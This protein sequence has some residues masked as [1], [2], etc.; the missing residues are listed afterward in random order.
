MVKR[1]TIV[2][3]LAWLAAVLPAGSAEA[4]FPGT[5]GLIAGL[6]GNPSFGI[7]TVKPDGTNR[8]L[9]ATPPSG[10]S[11][12]RWSAD[13]ERIA[14]SSGSNGHIHIMNADGSGDVDTGIVGTHPSW[15]PSGTRLVYLAG[16]VLVASDLDG[17]N[18]VQLTTSDFSFTVRDPVWSPD[19]TKIAFWAIQGCSRADIATVNP[20]GTGLTVLTTPA[21]HCDVD[22][23]YPTWSP[24]SQKLLF[25]AT[26]WFPDHSEPYLYTMNRDGSGIQRLKSTTSSDTPAWSPDGEL[27]ASESGFVF[28]TDGSDPRAVNVG[29]AADWQPVA[30]TGANI[31]T[32]VSDSPDPVVA[33]ATI[34]FLVRVKNLTG[35]QTATGVTMT[36]DVPPGYNL[37]DA[38]PSQGSCTNSGGHTSCALGSLAQGASATVT[39]HAEVPAY[40][41]P[42][43][44]DT[45]SASATQSDPDP[46]NNSDIEYTTIINY[47]RPRGATPLRVS[48]VPAFGACTA[49]NRQHGGPLSFGSCAPPAAQS[50]YLT[51]GTPDANGAAANSV[52]SMLFAVA[53]ADV[54]IAVS[55]TDVRTKSLVDYGGDLD[56]RAV[57]RL[58]DRA[59]GSG[60]V[61]PGTVT[62]WTLRMPVPCAP[63]SD[64]RIGSDCSSATTANALI[65]GLVVDGNRAIWELGQ[66]EV[67]DGGPD[68]S[69]STDD[70][71]PFLKQGVFA[72]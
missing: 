38:T 16:G 67:L 19:G 7:Y 56:A 60:A 28:R 10:S 26:F 13:G 30:S 33:G 70:G 8:T 47:P 12:P 57:V 53:N 50:P 45:A 49:P 32:I 35:T 29:I 5:N 20:D 42:G 25:L 1:L 2:V 17:S 39:L 55:V 24:D 4:S 58:T 59:N 41:G 3:G 27:I 18:A 66:V 9:I 6:S 22:Y 54:R 65:P 23:Q 61:Y 15:S 64:S 51:V 36:N 44:A 21:N 11:G 34:T 72:P 43:T 63:T 31:Q 69:F 52:G 46:T 48:L 14:Y 62:D 68:G 71:L 37:L 40:P